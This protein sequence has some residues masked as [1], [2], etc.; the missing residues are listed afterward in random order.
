MRKSN[1]TKLREWFR[2]EWAAY[3]KMNRIMQ[4]GFDP[5]ELVHKYN[6]AIADARRYRW[7]RDNKHLDIWWSVEGPKDRCDNIDADIDAAIEQQKEIDKKDTRPANCRYRL[8]AEGKAYPKSG[9]D[10]CKKN[11][12]EACLY[13]PN[14]KRPINESDS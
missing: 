7:L 13:D 9:C 8:H 11:I 5:H 12:W 6:E 10:A 3:Q 14:D 4:N 1:L 2:K